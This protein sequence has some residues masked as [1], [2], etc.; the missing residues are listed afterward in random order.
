MS[1]T[2]DVPES[3]AATILVVDDDPSILDMLTTRLSR[4]GYRIATCPDGENA[5]VEA[6]KTSAKL[7]VL[8]V[9]MPKVNGWEVARDLRQNPATKDIKIIMLT[10]IGPQMNEMTSP[11]HGA[12][13]YMD[14]PFNFKALEAKIRELIEG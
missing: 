2:A 4:L 5:V 13:A 9:M 1:S 3:P 10:A 11:L 8:D 6:V 12:D 14:K 7:V